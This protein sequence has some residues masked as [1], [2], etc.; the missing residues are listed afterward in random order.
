M[1]LIKTF[2]PTRSIYH[3]PNT[4]LPPPWP[5]GPRCA[6]R[7][8]LVACPASPPSPTPPL[9]FCP[10]G[11]A[12]TART[13]P[14][15]CRPLLAQPPCG[16]AT[17]LASCLPGRIPT[18]LRPTA[19]QPLLRVDPGASPS[20]DTASSSAESPNLLALCQY[21]YDCEV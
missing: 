14:M 1:K 10:Q 16:H 9:D 3:N 8:R 12:S 6:S 17:Q 19:R 2:D 15:P 4:P 13:T 11:A 7:P 5:S 21:M 20:H 18:R